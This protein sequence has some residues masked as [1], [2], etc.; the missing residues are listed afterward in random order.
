MAVTPFKIIKDDGSIDKQEYLRCIQFLED[1]IAGK[2]PVTAA[3]TWDSPWE[4]NEDIQR[5]SLEILEDEIKNAETNRLLTPTAFS[6]LKRFFR[7]YV[8]GRY[9]GIIYPYGRL[10]YSKN[11]L[12]QICDELDSEKPEV[13]MLKGHVPYVNN[14]ERTVIDVGF[15][16]DDAFFTQ[17]DKIR[18]KFGDRELTSLTINHSFCLKMLTPFQINQYQ[19]F[20]SSMY[21]YFSEVD[22]PIVRSGLT[23]YFEPR[24]QQNIIPTMATDNPVD[25]GQQCLGFPLDQVST[26]LATKKNESRL[27]DMSV[28]DG[29]YPDISTIY[30]FWL[31]Y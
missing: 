31:T 28:G 9:R 15:K 19:H 16:L 3:T 10:L 23:N 7:G 6:Q 4:L 13:L 11:K 21:F 5:S 26:L 14:S 2:V 12:N 27:L 22:D 8:K 30:D 20:Q 24:I 1:Y 18:A 25:A 17:A 29:E